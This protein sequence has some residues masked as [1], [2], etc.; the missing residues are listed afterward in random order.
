MVCVA[1]SA[2]AVYSDDVAI[3]PNYVLL[4]GAQP[5]PCVVAILN[6]LALFHVFVLSM[7]IHYI[8]QA[9]YLDIFKCCIIKKGSSNVGRSLSP[10]IDSKYSCHLSYKR[11][12]SY[13]CIISLSLFTFLSILCLSHVLR[14]TVRSISF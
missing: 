4:F 1:L 2:R 5:F 9:I 6:Q 11:R 10:I 7:V 3:C 12:T 13:V 8:L 14:K